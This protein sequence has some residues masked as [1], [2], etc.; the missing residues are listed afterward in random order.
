METMIEQMQKRNYR[1]LVSII[2]PVYNQEQFVSIAI[3]SVIRQTYKNWE[4][5]IIDDG[6][7]DNT[8]KII[9][10]FNDPRIRVISQKHLGLDGLGHTYNKALLMS[11][12]ELVAILE[13]DD[14]WPF[15]K[16][17]KQIEIFKDLE[18][19]L[20]FG[21]CIYVNE[22]GAIVGRSRGVKFTEAYGDK[23]RKMLLFRNFIPAVTVIVRRDSLVPEGF[24]AIKG[25]PF[26]D[27]PTWFT[28]TF[29]GKFVYINDVLGYWRR[30]SRQTTN[31]LWLMELGE[32]KTYCYF[33]SKG[34]INWTGL[35]L[36]VIISLIKYI[37][38]LLKRIFV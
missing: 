32:I 26:V 17:E 11:E 35:V 4:L 22:T 16:L 36:S 2:M 37:K 18:V 5:I 21:L 31:K 34:F 6:S 23:L 20:S 33:W 25:V 38:R 28:L 1:P 15:D 24:V 27:F 12:G 9:S 3:E 7:T 13:G 30:H 14:Y 29:K 10:N 8:L 19:V